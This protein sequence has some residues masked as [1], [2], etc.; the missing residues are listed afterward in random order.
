MHIYV[1]DFI[2][3][4]IL[5]TRNTIRIMNIMLFLPACYVSDT[6]KTPERLHKF[7][8]PEVT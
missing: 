1:I 5:G 3:I 4:N 7:Y 8:H 6:D 2:Q